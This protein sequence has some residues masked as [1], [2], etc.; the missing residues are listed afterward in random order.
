MQSN[1]NGSLSRRALAVVIL[2]WMAKGAET[3]LP[4]NNMSEGTRALAGVMGRIPGLSPADTQ[5]DAGSG[6]DWR[7]TALD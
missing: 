2:D 5:G 6:G 3:S 1:P 7:E 4:M